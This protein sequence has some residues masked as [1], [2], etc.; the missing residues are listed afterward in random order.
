[1]LFLIVTLAFEIVDSIP[2]GGADRIEFLQL[3]P[4]LSLRLPELSARHAKKSNDKAVQFDYWTRKASAYM[5]PTHPASD[6]SK[7]AK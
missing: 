7:K 6:E 1:L 4:H 5:P 2:T 3:R